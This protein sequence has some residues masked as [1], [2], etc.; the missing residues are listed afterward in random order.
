[1]AANG[2]SRLSTKQ[3]KQ[4]GKLAI[5]QAKR[6]GKIVAR[7]GTISGSIDDTKSYYR[8]LNSLDITMLPTKYTGNNITDNPNVGGLVVG[9]PWLAVPPSPVDLYGFFEQQLD[10]GTY[11]TFDETV[12]G[13]QVRFICTNFNGNPTFGSYVKVNGTVVASD[14]TVAPDGTD[15]T[16][17]GGVGFRMTRGHTLVVLNASGVVQDIAVYDTYGNVGLG[18][19]IATTL[20]LLPAG[21]LVAIG[22]YDA[23]GVNQNF[24]DALT[25]YFGDTTY[26]NTWGGQRISQMFLG[27]RNTTSLITQ[28]SLVFDG[29]SNRIQ[30]G[31]TRADWN[32]AYS[33][34]IEFWCKA[35]VASTTNTLLTPMSQQPNSGTIDILYYNGNFTVNNNT[36]I[37]TE[38]TVGVWTHVALVSTA[39]G[40]GGLKLYYNGVNV[41]TSAGYNLP[42]T[43]NDLWIGRRGNNNFQYFNGELANI[44]ISS[45]TRYTG[46]FTPPHTLVIDANTKLALDGGLV[47]RSASAHTI[48]NTGTTAST[49]FPT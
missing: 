30:V 29:S 43:A 25:N 11:I 47:D 18:D 9:R 19:L 46:T 21:Y 17:G 7:D 40:A 14:W 44:R 15:N 41:A 49:D 27:K 20:H 35:S 48:T 24:R 37:Y 22:T 34:T 3:L 45:G 23:T 1:M 5:A 4:E 12:L 36:V 16:V 28:Q 39:S 8:T 13:Q 26:T 10:G 31:G 38:P 42:D 6:Q 32:L 33:W 2:I